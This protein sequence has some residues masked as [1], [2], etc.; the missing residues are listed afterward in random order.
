MKK[1]KGPAI[2]VGILLII[3]IVASASA[4]F[5][6]ESVKKNVHIRC[7]ES[8]DG[9]CIEKISYDLQTDDLVVTLFN[10]LESPLKVLNSESVSLCFTL[11]KFISLALF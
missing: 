7:G 5:W 9:I 8:Y 1:K 2:T 10:G 6:L 11:A 3:T 4:F